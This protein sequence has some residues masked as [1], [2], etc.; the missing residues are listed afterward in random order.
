MTNSLERIFDGII[1]AL[2]TRVMPKIQDESA[3]GQAYGV[4]DMLRNL[5]PRVEWAAG[6]LQDDVTQ[7]LVLVTR[8]AALIDRAVPAA[9]AAPSD[10]TLPSRPTAADVEPMRDRLDRYLCA[11]LRWTDENRAR[12]PA[13]RAEEIETLIRDQQR[14]RL[15]REVKL[16]APALFGEISRPVTPVAGA[17][18]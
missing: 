4:L 8:I 11:V 6:P 7:Q 5:K 1:D 13:G 10:V 18:S 9:P 3:R 2:Q 17:R 12:L 15:K 14:V 16:T